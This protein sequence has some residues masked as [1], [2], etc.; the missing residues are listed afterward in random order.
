MASGERFRARTDHV[1]H[2]TVFR[3][4]FTSAHGRIDDLHILL[5]TQFIHPGDGRRMHG[6][7]NNDGRAGLR[8]FQH[9]V[10]S[11]DYLLHLAIVDYANL[12]YLGVLADLA[13]RMSDLCAF[14]SEFAQRFAADVIDRDVIARPDQIYREVFALHAQ[15]DKAYSHP[16]ASFRL[17][18]V[19]RLVF[20]DAKLLSSWLRSQT[21]KPPSFAGAARSVLHADKSRPE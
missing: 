2:C 16:S 11:G 19:H 20:A 8:A 21:R 10:R 17:V 4:R 1:A 15:T 12:D 6:A 13:I 5:P 3:A 14:S 7:V 9:A 18:T